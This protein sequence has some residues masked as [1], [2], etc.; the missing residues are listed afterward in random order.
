MSLVCLIVK[1]RSKNLAFY[2]IPLT[3][4]LQVRERDGHIDLRYHDLICYALISCC[5]SCSSMH[6]ILTRERPFPRH[7]QP[8]VIFAWLIVLS[9]EEIVAFN[10]NKLPLFRKLSVIW[11]QIY[12]VTSDWNLYSWVNLLFC[13]RES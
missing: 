2:I 10:C 5:L 12:C 1:L 13:S 9:F 7:F 6:A 11:W 8:K 3:E 4:R